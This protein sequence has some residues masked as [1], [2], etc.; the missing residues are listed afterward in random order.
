MNGVCPPAARYVAM[1]RPMMPRPIN[2]MVLMLYAL[3]DKG[4]ASQ[5][6]PPRV[7]IHSRSSR[8]NPA[9]LGG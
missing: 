1:G 5:S 2:P 9:H 6:P 7:C 8:H 4:A 3:Q